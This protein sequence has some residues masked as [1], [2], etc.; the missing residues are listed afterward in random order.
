MQRTLI[1]KQSRF[2]GSPVYFSKSKKT[3]YVMLV[4][5]IFG[6]LA[7]KVVVLYEASQAISFVIAI[8]I[9]MAIAWKPFVGI[10][11]LIVMKNTVIYGLPASLNLHGITLY[12]S[13]VIIIFMLMLLAV[14]LYS[15]KEFWRLKTPLTLPIFILYAYV[16]FLAFYSWRVK[17]IQFLHVMVTARNFFPYAIFLLVLGFIDTRDKLRIFIR[18]LFILAAISAILMLIQYII[19]PSYLIFF[20]GSKEL[21]GVYGPGSALRVA[22]IPAIPFIIL[23]FFISIASGV[24]GSSKRTKW[25]LGLLPTLL[26]T[27]ILVTF[28]RVRY[29]SI[30]IGLFMLLSFVKGKYRKKTIIIMFV[31]VLPL[32]MSLIINLLTSTSGSI[33]LANLSRRFASLYHVY[34]ID[35]FK[36]R[37]VM[38]GILW[39]YIRDFP[40]LGNGLGNRVFMGGYM[41]LGGDSDYFT[42][43]FQMGF[44]GAAIFGLLSVTFLVRS[45]YLLRWLMMDKYKAIVLGTTVYFITALIAGIVVRCFM[46]QACQII[47]LAII[48]GLNEVIYRI[49][50]KETMPARNT[51]TFK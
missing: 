30:L 10:L 24:I 27:S 12:P 39:T 8:C 2:P 50:R 49:D 16:I 22:W 11:M 40:I 34:Q 48:W 14:K 26:I 43:L 18:W 35:T 36:A 47:P 23:I 51:L 41:M 46:F 38:N 21:Q 1:L 17:G 44:I 15:K 29:V 45:F 33:F 42:M 3:V 13:E 6:L 20:P 9:L 4:F 5:C 32:V 7:A 31:I 28:S 37:G 19:G 25:V